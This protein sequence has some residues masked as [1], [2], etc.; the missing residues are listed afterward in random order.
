[1]KVPCAARHQ[2]HCMTMYGRV[3]HVKKFRFCYSPRSVPSQLDV[4]QF[5]QHH[6]TNCSFDYLNVARDEDCAFAW[7][8]VFFWTF[9]NRKMRRNNDYP[10][11]HDDDVQH[12]PFDD[13]DVFVEHRLPRYADRSSRGILQ[14]TEYIFPSSPRPHDRS[15]SRQIGPGCHVDAVSGDGCA[16][17]SAA[18]L[19]LDSRMDQLSSD[20]R[21]AVDLR[22]IAVEQR[23][24]ASRPCAHGP[25]FRQPRNQQYQWLVGQYKREL[26]LIEMNVELV[27]VAHLTVRQHSVEAWYRTEHSS[28]TVPQSCYYHRTPRLPRCLYLALV[29]LSLM[30]LRDVVLRRPQS[31]CRVLLQADVALIVL[32]LRSIQ[33][34]VHSCRS[35]LLAEVCKAS[36][37]LVGPVQGIDLAN[38]LDR[39]SLACKVH[40]LTGRG[41][42][43]YQYLCLD[44]DS[45]QPVHSGHLLIPPFCAD[46]R[47]EAGRRHCC[48]QSS[49]PYP[50]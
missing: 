46:V 37:I 29:L 43:C 49:A 44:F 40:N 17:V 19:C 22:R 7:Y 42:S 32:H 2:H 3:Q 50:I 30:Q 8:C 5:R 39:R 6:T 35:A 41:P 12:S 48:L 16:E 9:Q 47:A 11:R 18:E 10:Y 45:L 24:N 20:H 23:L 14:Y 34:P 36:C 1:M 15:T 25:S 31:V 21:V 38:E 27:S 4:C 13:S 28:S 33:M 26:G